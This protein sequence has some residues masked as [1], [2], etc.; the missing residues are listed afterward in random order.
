MKLIEQFNHRLN[1]SSEVI[2]NQDVSFRN[3]V[4]KTLEIIIQ[5]MSNKEN[6]CI[7]GA[8]QCRDFSLP[9]FI[10]LFNYTLLTDIDEKTVLEMVDTSSRLQ[11]KQV[12]YTGFDSYR[13]FQ[14]FKEQM[15]SSK[16]ILQIEQNI[17]EKLEAIKQ[18]TFL[19]EHFGL[20]DLVYVSPIY[21]QLVY[22]QILQECNLLRLSGF[23]EENIRHIESLMLD[24]MINVIDQFN[25]N[26]VSLLKDEGHL[27]VLSDIFELEHGSMFHKRI[28]NEINNIEMMNSIHKEYVGQYG[29]GLGD[30]GLYN[31]DKKMHEINSKWL[32]WTFTE[33]RS[34]AVKLK[35]YIKSDIEGGIL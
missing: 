31:L 13:F 34:Y 2:K 8:G 23:P 4:D 24:K 15:N 18:Y 17:N 33:K 29:M 19:Q 16:D 3:Q 12:E 28:A 26:I 11:F 25:N 32:L 9:I 5:S 21:S 20:M 6:A 14:D 1:Q 27:I 22:Q 7:I 30:Y 35:I 10:D